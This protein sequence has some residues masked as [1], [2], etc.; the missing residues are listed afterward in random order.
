MNRLT[1]VCKKQRGLAAVEM[2]ISIPVLLLVMMAITEFGNALIRYNTLNKMAQNGIRYATTDIAG[3]ASYD[4]IADISEIK[5]IVVYGHS[6]VGDGSTPMVEG[7][8]TSDVAVSHS[9][10][11]VTITISHEYT[12]MMT[13]FDTDFN[14]TVPLNSSAMMRTAP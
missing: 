5:N 8:S 13:A 2:I 12:P 14:F 6:S 3:S 4:Q 10:G 7:V 9:N 11:Y 1:P